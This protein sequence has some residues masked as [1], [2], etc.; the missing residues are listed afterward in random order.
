MKKL[1]ILLLTLLPVLCFAGLESSTYISGLV[2]TNPTGSDDRAQGDDHIRLLKSTILNTFPNITGAVTPTHTELNYVDG[3]TSALQTQLD[4][5]LASSG[6]TAADVLSKLLT[7]DGAAS[8]LDA[9]LLD[10]LSSAAFLRASNNLSDV[11]ASTARTNLGVTATGSDT[12]YNYR[13]NNLSDIADAAAARSNLGLVIG[14]HVLAPNGSA[15]SLTSFPTLNQNTSGNAATA[16]LAA[17]ATKASIPRR[18]SG[19]ADGELLSVSAGQTLNTSD[20]A[21]GRTFTLLNASGSAIT[22]TE[23]AGVTLHTAGGTDT[24]NVSIAAWGFATIWCESGSVAV[25]SGN[26]S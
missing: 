13:A 19:F 11:T 15:A 25:V 2:T 7:V 21:A 10:G 24:G 17:A 16:T 5:K 20:M 22:L 26:I 3:V 23:G 14:T 9:D 4:A 18:T 12:T 6:Y 1:R 8:T